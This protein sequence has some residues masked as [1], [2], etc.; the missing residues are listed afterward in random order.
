MRNEF[1]RYV[2][3]LKGCFCKHYSVLNTRVL[4]R[5]YYILLIKLQV[6]SFKEDLKI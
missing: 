5:I 2:G 4:G 3:R 1:D 6:L